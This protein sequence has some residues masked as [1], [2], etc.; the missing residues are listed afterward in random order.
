MGKVKTLPTKTSDKLSGK[1]DIAV[2]SYLFF[3]V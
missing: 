1:D 3:I 2:D